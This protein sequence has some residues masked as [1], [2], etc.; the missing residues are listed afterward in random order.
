MLTQKCLPS[1]GAGQ[2]RKSSSVEEQKLGPPPD[3]RASWDSFH[4][5]A[6]YKKGHF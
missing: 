3:T 4:G 5:F 6:E 1:R 2:E